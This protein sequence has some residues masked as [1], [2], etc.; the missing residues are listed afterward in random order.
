MCGL[1]TGVHLAVDASFHVLATVITAGQRSAA[2]LFAKFMERIRVP[3]VGGR[4]PA[5]PPEPCPCRP[6][7]DQAGHC[8]R[9]GSAGGRPPG[10]D[11]EMCK[12]RHRVQCRIGLLKQARA[13]AARYDTLAVR[14][15]AT[16]QLTLVRQA[17]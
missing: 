4:T 1:T 13:V 16:V 6:C 15:E 2:P 5:R 11:R 9:R 10:F 12:R 17:L 14:Y 7:G 3:G 8:L